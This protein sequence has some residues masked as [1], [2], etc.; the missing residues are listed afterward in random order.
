[1]K[2]FV[3]KNPTTKINISVSQGIF[4]KIVCIMTTTNILGYLNFSRAIEI[5]IKIDRRTIVEK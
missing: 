2:L 3:R 5:Y 1:V 4:N